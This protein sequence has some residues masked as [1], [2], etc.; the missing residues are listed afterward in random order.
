MTEQPDSISLF[1]ASVEKE[2]EF[3]HLTKSSIDKIVKH[4][5]N[6]IFF[7]EYAKMVVYA[8]I[9]KKAADKIWTEPS[10]TRVGNVH[11][12]FELY[13]IS[14]TINPELS[15]DLK[16][17]SREHSKRQTTVTEEDEE[18][19]PLKDRLNSIE[20]FLRENVI[21]QDESIDIILDVLY[22]TATGL[23][24]KN[25]PRAVILLTGPSGTGKCF[26]KDTPILMYDGT[27]KLIQDIKENDYVMGHDSTPRLVYGLDHGV[28]KLYKIIPVKGEP[29][30]VTGNHKLVLERIEDGARREHIITVED[31]LKL[32]D[33]NWRKELKLKRTG[34]EFK[35]SSVS[36]D[37]YFLGAWLGDGTSHSPMITT[38]DNEIVS[39]CYSIAE[40][41]GCT[42]C[43]HNPAS[44]CEFYSIISERGKPNKLLDEMR[45][46]CLIDNKHVPR[47]YLINS[48]EIRLNVL[49]GLIDTDGYVNFNCAE[50]TQKREQLADDIVFLARSLGLA[51]YKRIVN[52]SSQNG[53][54]GEYFKV[55]I[56]G[57]LSVIPTRIPK[58]KASIRK[59]IK[60]V[61]RT[62]FSVEEVGVGEYFGFETDGDHK[63][64]LG[65]FTITHN[66]LLAKTL[67]A[68]LYKNNPTPEDIDSPPNFLRIDCTLFQ[69]RHE[70]SNLIG[71]PAG[72]VGSDQG[73]PLPDFLKANPDGNIILIDEA[74]KAHASL[75]KIFMGLFDYG[76]IKDN[77][78]NETTAYNSIFIMTSN[79]GS[80]EALTDINKANAP[81]GFMSPEA[82]IEKIS[83]SSYKKAIESLFSP[84]M[85]GRIDEIVVFNHLSDESYKRIL[86]IELAKIYKNM[87]ANGYKI[88]VTNS[89]KRSIL[90]NGI[91]DELGARDLSHYVRS[92]ITKPLSRLIIKSGAKSF[93]CKVKDKELIVE[94]D[95]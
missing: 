92:N 31:Y 22:R 74:E 34:V 28:N 76:K 11:T 93:V 59:Q 68:A 12:L 29:F 86:E 27:T 83:K 20:K 4:R 87:N 38:K 54:V 37:P 24:D 8:V 1:C 51:A 43:R 73:S 64:L 2:L 17:N 60:S 72:Y 52:K 49:A 81:F 66:T 85:R 95:E 65:D 61:L 42:V 47:N 58:K 77:K 94:V 50:I 53:T 23:I 7:T 26:A 78:Q 80:K 55:S 71:S 36:I 30:I 19:K 5:D 33:S 15:W 67:C 16:T 39:A 75:H 41:F 6:I 82:N 9:G 91:S 70:I 69:Q 10:T 56:S 18:L 62:G 79:A 57:D 32:P 40:E 35:E 88:K 44:R 89:A 84:E 45:N 21:G 90:S 63:F 46:I 48:R 3:S 14:S 13:W 25:R